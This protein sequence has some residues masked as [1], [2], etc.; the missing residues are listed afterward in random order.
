MFVVGLLL[1]AQ[2]GSATPPKFAPNCLTPLDSAIT[3]ACAGDALMRR[4]VEPDAD[5]DQRDGSWEDAANAYR[6]AANL[7]TDPIVKRYALERLETV[8]DGQ[9]LDRARDADPVLRELIALTPSDLDPLFRLARVEEREEL[10]DAAESTL[11]AAKQMKPDE[12]APYRELA[13]FFAR[14][15]AA[16]SAEKARQERADRGPDSEDGPDKDGVYRLREGID[17]PKNLTSNWSAPL[18]AEATASGVTGAVALAIVV[19]SDGSVTDAK[20]IQSVPMLD[21]TA[22]ATVRQ[23]RFAPATLDGRA[24]PVRMTVVVNFKQH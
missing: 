24:V 22:I 10:F 23:W 18:S 14:R 19:G 21:D 11:L 7:A 6:R 15:A 16:L 8:F 9:H 20:V 4:A 1:V 3:L 12:I 5:D 17:P 2:T 13:Q